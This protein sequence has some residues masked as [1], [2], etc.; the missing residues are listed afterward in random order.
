MEGYEGNPERAGQMD[1]TEE[2]LA[3][4][5]AMKA[6]GYDAVGEGS[7]SRA[8]SAGRHLCRMGTKAWQSG[9]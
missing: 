4:R 6:M 9:T 3:Q 8:G 2:T 7:R 1:E 5:G